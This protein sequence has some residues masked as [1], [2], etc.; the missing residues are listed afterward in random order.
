MQGTMNDVF[1]LTQGSFQYASEIMKLV[2]WKH[3]SGCSIRMDLPGA[4]LTLEKSVRR[5]LQ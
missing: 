2:F 3:H 4:R 1:I 5:L